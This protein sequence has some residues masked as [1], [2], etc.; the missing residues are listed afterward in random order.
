MSAET[1]IAGRETAETIQRDA[2]NGVCQSEGAEG[3][4]HQKRLTA[5]TVIFGGSFVSY[6]NFG[7]A[8]LIRTAA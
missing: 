6:W 3:V 7:G 1:R 4:S 8:G 5:A 2:A